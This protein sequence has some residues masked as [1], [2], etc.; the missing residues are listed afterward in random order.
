[1]A[2]PHFL[3]RKSETI[4]VLQHHSPLRAPR[5]LGVRQKISQEFPM[6]PQ[7]PSL[8]DRLVPPWTSPVKPAQRSARP[9]VLVRNRGIRTIQKKLEFDEKK[10][11]GEKA[12]QIGLIK[13]AGSP[14]S[15]PG[16]GSGI[17]IADDMFLT[18]RHCIKASELTVAFTDF[19]NGVETKHAFKVERS[20]PAGTEEAE[21]YGLIAGEH[22]DLVLL[23]LSPSETTKKLPG[24]TRGF[25][26]IAKPTSETPK[27]LTH[28]G[29]KHGNGQIKCSESEIRPYALKDAVSRKW[30]KVGHALTW[31]NRQQGGLV[32]TVFERKG[33][34]FLK[35]KS[36]AGRYHTFR[37]APDGTVHKLNKSGII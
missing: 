27:R 5:Q 22:A 33:K 31:N 19:K 28:F 18:A 2:V 34:T 7:K 12:S 13:R 1:M 26:P 16:F 23:K 11:F 8:T 17:L 30:L 14:L 25:T 29:F 24:E 4:N 6:T 32:D 20:I 35:V 36:E 37:V 3:E 21:K 9:T 10:E 15:E